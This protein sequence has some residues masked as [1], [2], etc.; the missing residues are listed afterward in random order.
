MSTPIYKISDG[1]TIAFSTRG[2][3]KSAI[4]TK[5][6]GEV[7]KGREWLSS[8]IDEPGIAEEMLLANNIIDYNTGAPLPYTIEGAQ[9]QATPNTKSDNNVYEISRA[10]LTEVPD[11]TALNTAKVNNEISSQSNK[12]TESV[13]ESQLPPD[14]RFIN[15]LNSQKSTVKRR[16]I[17]F[18]IGLITPFAPQIISLIVSNL[19]INGDSTA[20]SIKSSAAGKVDVAASAAQGAVSSA[21]ETAKD[22]KAAAMFVL[23]QLPK[24]QLIDLINCPSSSKIQSTIKQR[25]QLVTQINGMYKS[26]T[27]LSVNLDILTKVNLALDAVLLAIAYIPYPVPINVIFKTVELQNFLNANSG[28]ISGLTISAAQYGVFLGITL[29]FLSML[30]IILQF[31]AEDKN[32]N[33]EQVNNEINALA[34]PTVV[35]TQSDNNT[36]KGFTLGVKIDETNESKYIR[37]YAV[38]ENKQG[39]PVLRTESSFASDPAVLINQLKFIIDTNPNITAE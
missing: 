6:N 24:E 28:K 30:D 34:N 16:L 23:G 29:K 13:L 5:P 22:P 2:P 19:G 35:A 26:I 27:T 25:N 15:F 31:C 8:A 9:D 7:I 1:S 3:L 37:R 36:Y 17:P 12:A 39:V 10:V 32:L 14:V 20:D 38:A 21:E 18:V 33:L 4:L 11:E